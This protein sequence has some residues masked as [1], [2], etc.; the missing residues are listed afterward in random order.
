MAGAGGPLLSP[1]LS[2]ARGSGSLGAALYGASS[3]AGLWGGT[4][5]TPAQLAVSAAAA[6]A[7]GG[8]PACVSVEEVVCRLAAVFP[9]ARLLQRD[10]ERRHARVAL[11]ARGLALGRVFQVRWWRGGSSG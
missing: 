1:S 2:S 7:A 10:E 6:G 5:L 3:S 9:G 8:G 4:S 11:P